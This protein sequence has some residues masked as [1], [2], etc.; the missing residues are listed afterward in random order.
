MVHRSP[1]LLA[2]LLL[3]EIPCR[4][5][6][7]A[8]YGRV[9]PSNL[10]TVV[11]WTKDPRNLLVSE[12]LHSALLTLKDQ[13][14]VQ[15]SLQVTATGWGGSFI[16]PGIPPWRTVRDS[17]QRLFAEGLASPEAAVYRYDPFLTVQTPAG[18]FL[19]NAQIAVFR[20]LC[21]AFTSLGIQRVTTSRADARRYPKVKGRVESLGLKW[22]FITDDE[23]VDLCAAMDKVCREFGVDFSVCCEPSASPLIA[24]WGCIDGA[25]L[26][27]IKGDDPPATEVLHNQIG[28]QRP[29]CRCTY[30]R[31]IGYST[32]SATCYSGGYG[33]LYCY[34]QGS[35]KLPH[36]EKILQGIAD[37]DKDPLAYLE[38][39]KLPAALCQSPYHH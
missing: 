36:I 17:L 23:A 14:G 16:E 11:L 4:W 38:N 28:K 19:S 20:E 22:V 15:I 37:F 35:A 25:W 30:S 9:D 24:H 7:Y 39:R 3:G 29:S 10:H 2:K 8:P 18:H 26:N 13:Y 33:C 21:T 27:R 31:D 34:S 6:P 32:G 5:G 12:S 1:D